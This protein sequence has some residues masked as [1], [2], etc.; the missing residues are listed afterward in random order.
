VQDILQS[1]PGVTRE[2]HSVGRSV[3][4]LEDPRLISGKGRF[5]DDI[6]VPGV[7]YMHIV[8]S[9]EAHAHI[10]SIKT[11]QATAAEGVRLVLTGEEITRDVRPLPVRWD[12]P[13]LRCREYPLVADER[14]RYV[15]QPIALIVADDPF[16]AEDAAASIDVDY[17]LLPAVV[18]VEEAFSPGS[19]L[20]YEEWG[21][22]ETCDPVHMGNSDAAAAAFAL[23][24]LV[25]KARLYSHRHS[26]FPLEPRGCVAVP[27]PVERQLLTLYSSTQAPNQVR[28]AVAWCLG[29]GENT[30]RV[31]AW[32]VGGGFGVKDQVYAED[33][34]V[35]YVA[36]RLG[37]PVKWIEGR[38]ESFYA[39]THAREQV[40]YAELALTL[41]GTVLAIKDE[42][43][44]DQGAFSQSRGALPGM[45][46][47]SMLPGPYAIGAADIV[48]HV[49][50]TNK[51][52]SA[53]YRGF[54]MTQSTFVLERLL[55]MAAAELGMDPA[56]IRRKNLLGPEQLPQFETATGIHYDSGDYIQAFERALRL[57][58]YEQERE[59]QAEL[60]AQGR[61]LGIG[62]APFVETTGLGPSGFQAMIGFLIPSHETVRVVMDMS[63]KVMVHT[64]IMSIGQG[65][66]TA[67]SQ[68]TA[69]ALGV[70]LE[71]VRLLYGDT[72]TSPYSGLA[73]VA[74]RS[75]AVVGAA[76]LLACEPLVEK[77]KLIASNRLEASPADIEIR[78][79]NISVSGV[80]GTTVPVSEIARAAYF[81]GPWLPEGVKPGLTNEEVY[82]PSAVPFAYGTHTC[83]V[84]VHPE[85]GFVE[86]LKYAVCHDCGTMVNPA[87][88]E[89]QIYGGVAQGLGGALMEELPYERSG[90]LLATNFTDYHLP[91]AAGIPTIL[92]EHM[93]TPSPHIPG[94]FKGAGEGGVIPA[95]AAIA[96]AVADALSPFGVSITATPLTPERVWNLVRYQQN[97]RVDNTGTRGKDQSK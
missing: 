35:S 19:P 39:S 83:L 66:Q 69:D 71:D 13:G 87:L 25:V 74:S 56:D 40:H 75:T 55:D 23:A 1:R 28:T 59:H 9:T 77:L 82:D 21:T 54:G 64:G 84:E 57:L 5:V 62:L 30:I 88:V 85:T 95:P 45:L 50:V 93:E 48:V 44:Y 11:D 24:D 94:G 46:T 10:R 38:T 81:R 60:R 3:K 33:V 97:A 2:K 89:G 79:G 52:S 36:R 29:V 92:I 6:K 27:H 47:A 18:D 7:L 91:R 17:D 65:A 43:F 20:L 4:R 26:G 15:G 68:I 49:V 14:V 80:P 86:V 63:G 67:L 58:G 16:L 51:V 12:T 70:P 78:T 32:D 73:S 31:Q 41:D 8:R 34:L 76:I 22:N 42:I 96:N 90:Q 61:Y 72:D 37:R 53:A